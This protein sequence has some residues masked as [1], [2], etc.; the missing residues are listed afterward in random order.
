MPLKLFGTDGIRGHSGDF[1][2]DKT[3][4]R[5]IGFVVAQTLAKRV[6]SP[7][8]VIGRDTRKNGDKLQENLCKGLIS[9]GAKTV[10]AGVCPT[11]AVVSLLFQNRADAGIMISAS[12]NPPEYNGFKIFNA[13][14]CKI[15]DEIEREIEECFE[16]LNEPP[17]ESENS[18]NSNEKSKWHE[19][20]SRFLENSVKDARDF[21]QIQIA[22]DCAN[23]AM[24]EIAPEVFEKTG[25]KLSVIGIEP[26]GENINKGCGSLETASLGNEIRQ[27]SALFGAS[28]DGDGDRV[29]FCDENGNEVDGD[30]ILALFAREMLKNG[31][32]KKPQIVATV[33]SN[34]GLEIFLEE[35]GIKLFRANVGDRNVADMMRNSG[36]NFGGEQSGHLIFSDHSTNGDGLLAALLM[37]DIVKKNNKPLSRLLPEFELFPQTLKNV[38]ISRGEPFDTIPGLPETVAKLEKQLGKTGRILIRYSGTEPLARIL[39]EGENSD[40]IEQAASELAGIIERRIG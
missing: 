35:I 9:G 26:N 7:Q 30:I 34:K 20:Y 25:A 3:G 23:G 29:S 33:M 28:L 22:L 5:Q 27:S 18:L 16:K 4:S 21:S 39:I 10:C 2:I 12:H 6:D 8:V 19:T 17:P 37:A 32:L 15:P 40:A 36:V 13:E 1:P 14:G 31:T 24:F 11:P 38:K